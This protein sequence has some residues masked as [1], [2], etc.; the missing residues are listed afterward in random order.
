[1]AAQLI[2]I[3]QVGIRFPIGPGPSI[4][5]T[6]TRFGLEQVYY[7]CTNNDYLCG[8]SIVANAARLHRAYQGFESLLP[9]QL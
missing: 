5:I 1:M 9:H 3:Q 8:G 4:I 7:T 6:S 2:C